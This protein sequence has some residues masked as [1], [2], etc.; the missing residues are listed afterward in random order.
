MENAI[1]TFF[2]REWMKER[3]AKRKPTMH[4]SS[5]SQIVMAFIDNLNRPRIIGY[6]KEL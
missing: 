1:D 4:A 2:R 6:Q 5:D 3:Y